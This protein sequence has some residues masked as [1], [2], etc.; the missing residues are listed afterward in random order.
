MG[1]LR[2]RELYRSRRRGLLPRRDR[3]W[4]RSPGAAS[5]LLSTGKGL[6]RGSGTWKGKEAAEKEKDYCQARLILSR[7]K[8]VALSTRTADFLCTAEA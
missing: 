8:K 1:G 7:G 3:P 6:G 4:R 5:I 2:E